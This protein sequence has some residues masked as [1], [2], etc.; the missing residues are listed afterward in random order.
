MPMRLSELHPSNVHFPVV[1]VPLAVGA[2]AVG[3]LTGSRRAREMGETC[4]VGATIA[5]AV[6]GVFGLIAQEEVELDDAGRDVLKTHRTLNLCGL[7]AVGT[8]ALLRVR[9]E[10]PSL[11]YVLAGLGVCAVVAVSAYLGGR[12]VYDHGAGVARTRGTHDPDLHLRDAL[13]ITARAAKDVGRGV[14]HAAKDTAKGDIL[15]AL[16]AR[17]A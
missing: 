9:R 17:G 15:P 7:A 16:S 8:M 1:L 2:D 11:G 3:Y 6:A 14:V 12:L 10:K 5:A 4:I 13:A